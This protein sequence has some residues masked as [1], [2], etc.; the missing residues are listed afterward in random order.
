VLLSVAVLL[1]AQ[2]PAPE[3]QVLLTKRAGASAQLTESIA[4]EL[5]KALSYSGVEPSIPPAELS[6]R[7][8]AVG[9]KDPTSC[10][11]KPGCA[12]ELGKQLKVPL[13]VSLSVKQAAGDLTVRV[14]ALR[15]S[16]SELV[17]EDTVMLAPNQLGPLF[18][19]LA[20]FARGVRQAISPVRLAPRAVDAPKKEPKNVPVALVPEPPVTQPVV[21]T[22][23]AVAKPSPMPAIAAG[24]ATVVA[25]GAT[26]FFLSS[27]LAVKSQLDQR[28]DLGGGQQGSILTH[29]EAEQLAQSANGRL[30]AGVLCAVTTVA[31]GA[32]TGFL[33]DRAVSHD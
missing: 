9:V 16:D 14:E 17:A 18:T 2:A 26:A 12:I 11:A 28:I 25:L 27:G 8:L 30:T 7:L 1:L 32:V 23:V 31:L 22:S 6:A 10:D 4:R 20:P 21:P 24:G 33:W 3:A 15:T 13:V 5:R 19:S 29:S